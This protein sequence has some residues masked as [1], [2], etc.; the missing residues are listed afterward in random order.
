MGKHFV[1]AQPGGIYH[2]RA[3]GFDKRAVRARGVVVVTTLDGRGDLLDIASRLG[4]TTL[5][6][7]RGEA[8][9]YSFNSASGRR[10]NRYRGLRALR[11][12]ARSPGPAGAA[13]VRRARL[14]AATALTAVVTSWLRISACVDAVDQDAIVADFQRQVA[15]QLSYDVEI[16]RCRCAAHRRIRDRGTSPRDRGTPD[17]AGLRGPGPRC[18]CRRRP[19]HRWQ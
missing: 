13:P 7:T 1:D 16:Q 11:R 12:R 18:S 15:C 5:E 9:R 2:D 3:V 10:P 8:V 14:F 17:R 19:D 6:R 4:N